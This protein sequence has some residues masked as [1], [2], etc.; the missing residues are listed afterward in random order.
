MTPPSPPTRV[1]VVEDSATQRAFLRQS[2]EAEGDIVVIGEA[3]TAASAVAAVVHNAPDIVTVDLDIP[4]GGHSLIERIMR[5]TPRPILVLSGQINSRN[6]EA[7]KALGAGAVAVMAKPMRWDEASQ[8][9]LRRRVRNLRAMKVEKTVTK[10]GRSPASAVDAA[11]TVAEQTARRGTIPRPAGPTTKQ[12]LAIGA[13]TGGPGAIAE[14]LRGLRGL[15]IPV[16]VVQHIGPQSVHGLAEWLAR[17]SGWPVSVATDGQH[18][19]KG[20]VLLGPHGRH[21]VAVEGGKVTLSDQP[22]TAHRPSADQ[23]FQ[24]VARVSGSNGIGILLTGM[25]SDGAA[26]LLAMR[27]AGALTIVQD[28]ASSAVYGM[29]KAAY[30]LGAARHSLALS[31]IAP[32]VLRLTRSVW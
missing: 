28:E 3:A 20:E 6:Q 24:S 26:G 16:L 8:K 32:T 29:P 2:L 18:T 11:A 22:A 31:A 14:V 13:S 19:T 25:G 7:T 21:L 15:E 27:Q 4:G 5:S 9:E 17:S 23:L 12:V 10:D 1:V 30:D